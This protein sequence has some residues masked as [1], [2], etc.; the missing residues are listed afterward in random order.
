MTEKPEGH[1]LGDRDAL[2]TVAEPFAF[3]AIEKKSGLTRFIQHPA[4]EL[5]D[6]IAPYQLR[7]VRILNGAHTALVSK[8]LPLGFK[9]VREAVSHPEIEN[10]LRNLLF[11]EIVPTVVDRVQNAEIFAKATLERFSNP[12]LNHLL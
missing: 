5:V 10:W 11:E 12:F 2:L 7:K 8:A 9:T 6:D 1:A 3:W 4:I